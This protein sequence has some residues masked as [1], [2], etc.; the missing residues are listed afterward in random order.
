LGLSQQILLL[1]SN[2]GGKVMRANGGS[3]NKSK[4][5]RK[6]YEKELRELQIHSV[7]GV[8]AVMVVWNFVL[9]FY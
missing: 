9:F 5:K 8:M 3:D 2:L 4:L 1:A 7:V 6:V